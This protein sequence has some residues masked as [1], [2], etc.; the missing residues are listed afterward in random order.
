[1]SLYQKI[2]NENTQRALKT[3]YS[4]LQALLESKPLPN[5]LHTKVLVVRYRRTFDFD[6]IDLNDVSYTKDFAII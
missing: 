2:S 5:K 3:I 1:M 4:R 6:K